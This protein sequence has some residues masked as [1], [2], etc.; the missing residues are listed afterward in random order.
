VDG[1]SALPRPP[2]DSGREWTIL[3]PNWF[4]QNF[5]HG[6]FTAGLREPGELALPAGDGRVGFV[7]TR[8][9][10]DVAA[11]A[12]A[13]E[14]HAGAVHTLT[15]PHT[16]TFEQAGAQISAAAGWPM[17]YT[18]LTVQEYAD[19]LRGF[20]VPEWAVVWQTGLFRLIREGANGLV[21]DT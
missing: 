12:L 11:L 7:D 19:H 5:G 20:S 3:R 13:T 8:D 21:A 4:H 6:Y 16:L 17:K 1:G 9:I 14:G 15:G 10:G 18:G 2:V